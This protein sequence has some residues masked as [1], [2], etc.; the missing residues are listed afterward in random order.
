MST[1]T[2]SPF[3][4]HIGGRVRQRRQALGMTQ[5][6]LGAA[7]G[8]SFQQLQKYE[9]GNNRIP[10]SRMQAIASALRTPVGFFFEGLG[11]QAAPPAEPDPA[12]ALLSAQEGP[13]LAEA[14]L[15]LSPAGRAALVTVAQAMADA[16]PAPANVVALAPSRRRFTRRRAD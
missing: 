4:A 6:A 9:Q 15:R 2:P 7:I 14:F 5:T 16:A 1:K 8:V 13:A 11:D 10:G 12:A 3:D